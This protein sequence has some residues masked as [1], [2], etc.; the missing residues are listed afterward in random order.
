LG[1]A[2]EHSILSKWYKHVLKPEWAGLVT[3]ARTWVASATLSA[4]YLS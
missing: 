3:A 2:A 4:A 1:S